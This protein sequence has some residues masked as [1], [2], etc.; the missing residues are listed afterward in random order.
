MKK[1]IQVRAKAD[2]IE[3]SFPHTA[4]KTLVRIDQKDK[5]QIIIKSEK[6]ANQIQEMINSEE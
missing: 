1:F 4:F 3:L 5:S 2:N 6:L